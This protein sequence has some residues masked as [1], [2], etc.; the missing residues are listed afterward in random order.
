[1]LVVFKRV[2][3]TILRYG[4]F[5]PAQGVGVAVS[6]GADS[7]CLLDVLHELAPRWALELV[8][9]H[10]D[11]QL[12]GDES[13]A[14]AAFVRELAQRLGLRAYFQ[15]VDVRGI[16][17]ATGDN[18]EQAARRARREFFLEFLKDGRLDRVALGHTRSDQAETVLFRFLRGA[19]TAG[20]AGMRPVTPEGFVRPLLE[21]D[22]AEVLAYLRQRGIPW[23][24]DSSNADRGFARNRIRHDLLPALMREWN[25]ALAQTLAHTAQLAQDEEQY[26]GR[27][28]E[29]LAATHLEVRPPAVFLR[30]GTLKELPPALARRL[31]RRAIELA[32]GDLRRIGFPHVEQVLRLAGLEKGHGRAQVPG[33]DV[34][35]SFDW[36]RLVPPGQSGLERRGDRLTVSVPGRYALPGSSVTIGLEL[37][38]LFRGEEKEQPASGTGYNTRGSELDWQRVSGAL[39]LRNW[40]PGDQYR[41]VGHTSQVKIKLL[42]HRAR[43]PVWERRGWPIITCGEAIVWAAR[44]GPAADFAATP[45][46]RTVLRV[47]EIGEFT[48]N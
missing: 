37:V 14:D 47:Q 32:R 22:R 10:L 48:E 40:R 27:E 29:R 26:W 17:Q 42:F 13:A 30:A 20:L 21:I 23:R 31:V 3:Q 5:A 7:V 6:G 39:E 24:E 18:L 9:L 16:S 4:M 46:S 38:E 12:R 45:A 34:L 11:H 15:Q 33:L 41:P 35:R 19:G 43:V 28:V 44:F 8:V 25:P 36:I 2:E 1:M